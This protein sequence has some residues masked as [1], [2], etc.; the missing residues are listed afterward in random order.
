MPGHSTQSPIG[1]T[2]T[3]ARLSTA[4]MVLSTTTINS[5]GKILSLLV[6]TG[7]GIVNTHLAYT[8]K[9]LANMKISKKITYTC[10]V[11]KWSKITM[12]N[13]NILKA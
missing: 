7:S 10:I 12:S 13:K 2:I 4:T 9:V 1:T 5:I 3:M 11:M 8:M 6:M